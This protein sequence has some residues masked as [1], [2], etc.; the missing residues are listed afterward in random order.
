MSIV[1]TVNC[2][3]EKDPHSAHPFYPCRLGG[4]VATSQIIFVFV[5]FPSS[6]HVHLKKKRAATQVTLKQLADVE[7]AS[8]QL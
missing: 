4:I 7:N 3:I 8:L 1:N 5:F 6:A 2:D